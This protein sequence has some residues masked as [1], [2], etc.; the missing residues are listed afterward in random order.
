MIRGPI[1]FDLIH[2]KGEVDKLSWMLANTALSY[3]HI[4]NEFGVTRQRIAY[5]AQRLGVDGQQ[6]L[7]ERNLIRPPRI[8]IKK[9]PSD[10]AAVI[11]KL[12]HRGLRVEPTDF[13]ATWVK[14]SYRR[15]LTKVF[16][17]GV[18]CSIQV[19]SA[20]TLAPSGR[21]YVRFDVGRETLRVKGSVCAMRKGR[22]LILYFV[23]TSHLRNVKAFYIPATNRY[24]ENPIVKR[25]KDWTV[26]R[27]AWHLLDNR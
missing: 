17:N 23:P 6:R 5:L 3:Q 26:Y 11:K 12:K 8:I 27:D 19:Q 15:S 1:R 24:A 4:A 16:V 9:Y 25:K 20:Q 7:R 2:G 22:S 13:R 21:Q 18:L 10:I 14:N